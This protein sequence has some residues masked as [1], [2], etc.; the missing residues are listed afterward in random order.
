M[1]IDRSVLLDA[2]GRPL[3]RPVAYLDEYTLSD[4]FDGKRGVGPHVEIHAHLAAVIEDV[5]RKG[6]LCMSFVH[7]VE[8]ANRPRL[9]EA[10]AVARWL[11]G[12]EPMWFRSNDAAEAELADAVARKLGLDDAHSP[13]LPIYPAMTAALR[14]NMKSLSVAGSVE[15]LG[16]PTIAGTVRAAHGRLER[17]KVA[18][19]SI[20]LFER[21]HV[22]RS[23]VPPEATSE[24]VV[25]KARLKLGW[26]LQIQAREAIDG[27]PI[28]IG[29]RRPTHVEITDAVL[30]LLA[31]HEALPFNKVAAHVFRNVGDRITQQT[32][33][34]G[35]FDERYEGFAMD[36][37][38][39]LAAAAVDVFT[40]DSFMDDVMGDFRTSRGMNRQVSLRGR[41]REAF[42]TELRRQ[43]A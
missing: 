4:A 42:V 41:S 2:G 13:R 31:E 37:R 30:A 9:E 14:G 34:S 33:R 43:C 1:A 17:A 25:A 21:F 36:T 29:E 19:Q 38:H 40:C 3:R 15:W 8:L 18:A 23:T 39:A 20:E 27:R 12:L 6:T 11:D 10:L 22:D 5:A 7:L 35:G 16:A 24:E 28:I 26:Q 32:L